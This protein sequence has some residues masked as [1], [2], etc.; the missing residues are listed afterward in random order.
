MESQVRFGELSV[1]GFRRL[2]DVHLPMRPLCVMI[3]ANG[4]G[5]TSVLDVLSLLAN[6]AQ[7]RLADSLS[8]LGALPAILTYDRPHNNLSLAI[9]IEQEA[10]SQ[11]REPLPARPFYHIVSRWPSVAYYDADEGRLHPPVGSLAS[12][13]QRSLK[14]R[15]CFNSPRTFENAWRP[16]PFTTS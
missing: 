10:L 1:Q 12:T 14:F 9:S 6:S 15:R 11:Q 8:D 13:R 2:Q 16:P 5:K 7:G 4:S 3:G